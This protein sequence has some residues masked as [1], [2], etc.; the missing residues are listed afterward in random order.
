MFKCL[1][2]YCLKKFEDY[3]IEF[4]K[5]ESVAKSQLT[6]EEK[7]CIIKEDN[8]KL[9]HEFLETALLSMKILKLIL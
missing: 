6:N 4:L 9:D 8:F 5:N 2:G 3:M 1:R 7:T